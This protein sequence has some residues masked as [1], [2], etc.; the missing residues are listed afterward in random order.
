MAVLHSGHRQRVGAAVALEGQVLGR[1]DGL[2]G[3]RS[4]AEGGAVAGQLQLSHAGY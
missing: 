3:S 2:M 1:A 4:C